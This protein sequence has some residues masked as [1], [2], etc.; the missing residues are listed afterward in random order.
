MVDEQSQLIISPAPAASAEVRACFMRYFAELDRRFETGFD[1]TRSIRADAADL[2]PPAGLVLLARIRQE[3]VAC[4]AL[5]LHPDGIAE[6]KRMWVSP[7]MRGLGLGGRMLRELERHA[8]EHGARVIHLETNRSL[9]EAIAL[10]RRSGYLEVPAFNDEPFAH[11]WF[12]KR[13][14]AT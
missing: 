10:Y 6:L 14:A 9:T 11:H 1:V 12:E 7:H 13:L 5:K 2:T 8:V 4:G 3:P